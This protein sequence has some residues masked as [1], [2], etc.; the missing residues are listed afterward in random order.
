MIGNLIKKYLQDKGIKQN[1]VA[2]K[3]GITEN[4]MS[5]ICNGKRD[6][7]CTEYYKICKVLGVPL[8]YFL[9]GVEL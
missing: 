6:V 1:F 5:D 2:E 9:E 4:A 8:E 3:A 7:E